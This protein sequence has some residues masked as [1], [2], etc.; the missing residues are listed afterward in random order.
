MSHY[1][2]P[3]L[4]DREVAQCLNELGLN[5]SIELL[6]KPTFEFV[7]PIYENLVAALMGISRLVPPSTEWVLLMLSYIS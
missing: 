2:F 3:I 1:S 6:S 5:A 4:S 7:Q